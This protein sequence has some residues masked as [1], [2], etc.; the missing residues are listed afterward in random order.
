MLMKRLLCLLL[1]LAVACLTAGCRREKPAERQDWKA[2]EEKG[3]LRIGVTECA[4]FSQKN[5][6]GSWSGFDVDL[7]REVCQQLELKP[8]V[9]ELDWSG[10]V[11]ALNRGEVDC[12]WSGLTA[13]SDM[14]ETLDF[15]QTYLASRP[16]LVIRWDEVEQYQ[17]AEQLKGKTVAVEA[18]SAGQSAALACLPEEVSVEPVG[19]QQAALEAVLNG[20][21]QGAVVDL[22]VAQAAVEVHRELTVQTRVELGTEELAAAL[23]HGSDLTD[24]L[25]RALAALQKDGTLDTLAEQYGLTGGLIS[26]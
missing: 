17:T 7:A 3:V 22:L 11:E 20:T 9:V 24:R 10:R 15:T 26:G 2:I 23:P 14:L 4:P 6:D 25:N 8:E 5:A 1:A 13:R 19:S 18:G 16:A 21:A 12:L